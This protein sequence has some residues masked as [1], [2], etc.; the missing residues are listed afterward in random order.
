M[1]SLLLQHGIA[2]I[3]SI[4]FT[5]LLV[6][7]IISFA[8][9][10][11]ILDIPHGSLKTHKIPTP[12]LGGVAI[13]GGILITLCFF[14][15]TLISLVHAQLTWLLIG[16]TGMLLV[17][18]YDD[19]YVAT[20]TQKFLGQFVCV[21]MLIKGGFVLK[22]AFFS[23]SILA[24]AASVFLMLSVIN[25]FNLVDVMDG[26]ATTLGLC[27]GVTFFALAV[28]ARNY[29]M[30]L[31]L[32]IFCGALIG[33]LPFNK[34]PAR[35]YLGDA[36][37]L[38]IGAFLSAI[39]LIFSWSEYTPLGFFSPII[40]LG[41]PLLEVTMLVLIRLYLGIRPY[42]GSPHHFA[43]FLQRKG[44]GK[45]MI[46][47]WTAAMSLILSA[48]AVSFMY[49][50]ISFVILFGGLCLFFVHWV[51]VVIGSLKNIQR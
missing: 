9:R 47:C 12:Y 7:L 27:S 13:Y 40:I 14:L 26:L 34:P 39:P 17:G 29:S 10:F 15:P 28:A 6:P 49:G 22:E 23:H 3:L 45:G 31:L 44:W 51:Y 20:P 24:T 25:A 35:I 32:I 42:H 5:R 16:S 30:S 43:L 21:G 46:L 37:A 2:L 8:H 4:V 41:I 48:L 38:F 18:L 1:N 33:F 11:D 19:V 50:Q 36:G